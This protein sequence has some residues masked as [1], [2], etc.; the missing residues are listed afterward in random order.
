MKKLFIINPRAGKGTDALGLAAEINRIS[1]EL[2]EDV[3]VYITKEVGDA[4]RFVEEYLGEHGVARIISCGGDGTLGEVLNGAADF[5][6]TQIGVIPRGT[7]NDFCRNFGEGLNFESIE[8]QIKGECVKCD[9]IVWRTTTEKGVHSGL[10]GNMFNIGFDCNVA[11][12][13]GHMKKNSILSGPFAYL[14]SIFVTLIKKKGANLSIE[15]DGCEVHRGPLLLTSVANGCFCGGGIKSNPTASLHDGLMNV[16]IIKNVPRL[17]LL[18]LLPYY[19][20]GT[21]MKLKNIEK[22]ISELDCKKA[23][24]TPLECKMRLCIDGEI[25]DA[26]ITEFEVVQDAFNFVLP[27]L[28]TAKITAKV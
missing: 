3:E 16:N 1:E 26:G 5:P 9:A 21:H 28:K 13:T 24:I 20:K 8:A 25:C 23:V 17:R 12:L 14:Y 11:D 6:E 7:G 22:I 18:T 19:M 4:R 27:D 2:N 10:C 15:L